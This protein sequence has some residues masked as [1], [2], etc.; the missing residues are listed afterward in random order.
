MVIPVIINKENN[1]VN[2]LN[3]NALIIILMEIMLTQTKIIVKNYLQIV[4]HLFNVIMVLKDKPAKI[5]FAIPPLIKIAIN[6]N[7]MQLVYK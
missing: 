1:F 7:K 5:I 4:I 2:L 3:K 6:V